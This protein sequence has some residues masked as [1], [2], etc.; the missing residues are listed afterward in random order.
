MG[1]GLLTSAGKRT[2]MAR[3]SDLPYRIHRYRNTQGKIWEHTLWYYVGDKAMRPV[4][5][6]HSNSPIAP[7][8]LRD[9]QARL[10]S[11]YFM[12]KQGIV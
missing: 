12:D 10:N 7:P 1:V 2:V 5:D 4:A 9:M 11:K 8:D 6:R 3:K